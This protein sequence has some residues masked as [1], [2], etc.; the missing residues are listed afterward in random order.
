MTK[1][2]K[3]W[4]RQEIQGIFWSEGSGLNVG[5][6]HC[7]KITVVMEN[8]EMAGVAWFHIEY[9]ND[10]EDQ[11]YNSKFVEGVTL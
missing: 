6:R 1:T 10:Q 9:D 5:Q 4:D 3:F 8:G 11:K 7:K 2:C